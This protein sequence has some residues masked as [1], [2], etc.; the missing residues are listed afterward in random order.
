LEKI[1]QHQTDVELSRQIYNI[2]GG[3]VIIEGTD[4]SELFPDLYPSPVG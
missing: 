4:L 3:S 1:Q 2:T